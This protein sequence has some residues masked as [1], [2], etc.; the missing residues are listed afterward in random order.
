LTIGVTV[1]FSTIG[2]GGICLDVVRPYRLACFAWMRDTMKDIRIQVPRTDPVVICGN[3]KGVEPVFVWYWLQ[4]GSR[5]GWN[6]ELPLATA[7]ARQ[8]WGFHEGVSADGACQQLE[9]KLSKQ[10]PRWH[11][12]NRLFFTYQPRTRRESTERCEI[13]CFVRP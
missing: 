9:E 2:L 13:F 5:D 7:S 11:L 1:F 6:G 4:D 3:T 8:V 10:D 12:M